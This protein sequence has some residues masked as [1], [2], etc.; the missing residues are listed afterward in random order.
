MMIIGSFS[1]DDGDDG[2]NVTTEMNSL[3]F[4]FSSLLKMSNVG[5]CPRAG[6]LGTVLKFRK[7]KKNS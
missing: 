3:F 7:R 5:E 4:Y 6:F 1:I 2:D